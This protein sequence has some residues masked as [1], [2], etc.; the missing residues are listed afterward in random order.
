[1]SGLVTRLSC[2]CMLTVWAGS[3]A[4]Y[5][6]AGYVNQYSIR[7][8]IH[9]L[10]K[11][12][13]ELEQ[14]VLD[15][16]PLQ[17][18]VFLEDHSVLAFRVTAGVGRAAYDRYVTNGTNDDSPLD[19]SDLPCGCLTVNGSL[20]CDRHYRSRI[21]DDWPGSLIDTVRWFPLRYI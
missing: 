9:Q 13:W 11:R 14:R 6:Y 15:P 4:H 8:E 7:S 17:G 10:R 3:L 20:P 2:L 18:L 16:H 5:S 12:L 19:R 21:L 1:M